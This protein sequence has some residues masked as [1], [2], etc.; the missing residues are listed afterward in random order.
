[1]IMAMAI[2]SHH[3]ISPGERPVVIMI[4]EIFG[5]R[6]CRARLGDAFSR[7]QKLTRQSDHQA[8]KAHFP[9]SNVKTIVARE[10]GR[11]TEAATPEV[12]TQEEATLSNQQ[13]PR[14][15]KWRRKA[16]L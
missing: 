12:P 3:A 8:A 9:T 4:E 5:A 16:T 15:T 10:E 1:M 11:I 13:I 14:Q 6:V 7:D 2:I